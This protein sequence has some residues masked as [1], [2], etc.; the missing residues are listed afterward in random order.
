MA[1]TI[2]KPEETVP[3]RLA[4]AAS[5]LEMARLLQL[6]ASKALNSDLIPGELHRDVLFAMDATRD[7]LVALADF[8][9]RLAESQHGEALT[10]A[11]MECERR[12]ELIEQAERAVRR[13]DDG[14]GAM[15]A[16]KTAVH[17]A[18]YLAQDELDQCR[19]MP[20]DR[21]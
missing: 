14:S 21:R 18:R 8:N 12:L 13:A 10:T 6:E 1:V 5:R 3:S 11:E 2:S 16:A 9:A 7:N 17:Q 20:E 19:V 15:G 4:R